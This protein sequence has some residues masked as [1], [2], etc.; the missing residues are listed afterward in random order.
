MTKK[1]LYDA[2]YHQRHRERILARQRAYYHRK[3]RQEMAQKFG[4]EWVQKRELT[5]E[6]KEENRKCY[7]RDHKQE[8]RDVLKKA[9][10]FMDSVDLT[11]RGYYRKIQPMINTATGKPVE[12]PAC[13][14][15]DN[16][17]QIRGGLC[18]DCFCGQLHEFLVEQEERKINEA[19]HVK[20]AQQKQ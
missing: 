1:E 3:K 19:N 8:I 10:A 12:C 9:V 14:K 6:Q 4:M 2:E 5:S 17:Y 20:Y 15:L 18:C 7:I 13:G 11:N 16:D